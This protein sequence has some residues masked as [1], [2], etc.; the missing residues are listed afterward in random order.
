MAEESSF[1]QEWTA[2]ITD[3]V[4]GNIRWA[5]RAIS[6]VVQ[7]QWSQAHKKEFLELFQAL[8]FEASTLNLSDRNRVIYPSKPIADHYH[9]AYLD[10]RVKRA[11]EVLMEVELWDLGR[12]ISPGA[13]PAE[14][15]GK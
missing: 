13:K 5:H 3:P 10:L 8:A 6:T 2:L 12:T 11:R 4:W 14:G 15:L 9:E 1:D 7:E